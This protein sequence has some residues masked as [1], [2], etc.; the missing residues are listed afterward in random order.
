VPPRS[1]KCDLADQLVAAAAQQHPQRRVGLQDAAV[2]G[3]QGHADGG[4]REGAVEAPFAG[5][6]LLH[7][8]GRQ[9]GLALAAAAP[10]AAHGGVGFLL[11]E[12]E[13]Q[14]GQH[15]RQHRHHG[16]QHAD[17]RL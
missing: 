15:H 14:R 17:A 6:Q 10:A 11:P 12:H 7:V 1:W 5:F 13:V 2:E 4:V 3:Q 16:H 9:L 8:A